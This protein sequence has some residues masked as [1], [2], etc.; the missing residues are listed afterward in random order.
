MTS[1]IET[2]REILRSTIGDAYYQRRRDSTNS[3][4]EPLRRLTDEYCFGEVWGDPALPPKIRSMLVVALLACL[5]RNN[6]LKT[7][8]GG[9]INNGCNVEELRGVLLQVAIYC[10]IPAGVESTRIAEEVLRERGLL[11]SGASGTP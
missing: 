1:R 3:F 7:H 5:G 11:D 9:A 8:L 2:G 10:G 4:N 6:E